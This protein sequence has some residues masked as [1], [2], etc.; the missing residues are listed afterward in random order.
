MFDIEMAKLTALALAEEAYNKGALFSSMPDEHCIASQHCD[1]E[2]LD[3]ITA[4][5][6]I[7]GIDG[8]ALDD[9]EAIVLST[10][11]EAYPTLPAGV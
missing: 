5:T 2:T 1:P 11:Q 3:T 6:L 7:E 10:L 8:M 9:A 4:L